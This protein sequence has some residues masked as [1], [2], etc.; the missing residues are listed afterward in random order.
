MPLVRDP[1][2]HTFKASKDALEAGVSCKE[3]GWTCTLANILPDTQEPEPEPIHE[4]PAPDAESAEATPE[5][6][7]DDEA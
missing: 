1:Q 4:P 7:E 3:C 6:D 2:G 5:N